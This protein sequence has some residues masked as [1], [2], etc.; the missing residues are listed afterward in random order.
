MASVNF[1][2]KLV[3]ELFIKKWDF[4]DATKT[5]HTLSVI[6]P[7]LPVLFLP[8]CGLFRSGTEIPGGT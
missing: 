3:C 5:E 8:Y 4:T 2:F 6:A 7:V 1:I